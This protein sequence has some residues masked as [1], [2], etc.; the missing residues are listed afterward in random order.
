MPAVQAIICE[1]EPLPVVFDPD[2]ALDPDAP[3]IGPDRPDGK[4]PNFLDLLIVRQG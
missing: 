3:Q 4:H 2:H 1:L